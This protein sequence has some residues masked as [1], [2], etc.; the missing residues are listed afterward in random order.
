MKPNQ[1]NDGVAN[2]TLV[3]IQMRANAMLWPVTVHQRIFRNFIP[4]NMTFSL[5]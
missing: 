1:R 4:I 3:P 5:F 2:Y